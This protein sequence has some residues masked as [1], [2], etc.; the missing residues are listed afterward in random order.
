MAH[1]SEKLEERDPKS[2]SLN[3][4]LAV[5]NPISKCAKSDR[6]KRANG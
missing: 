3:K 4:H 1:P 5:T 6:E 2:R